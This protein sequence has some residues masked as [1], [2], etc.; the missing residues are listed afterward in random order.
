MRTILVDNYDS[1]SYNVFQLMA[2]TFGVEPTVLANDAPEWADIDLA[3]YAAVVIS[4]GPGSPAEPGDRGVALDHLRAGT[5]PVLGV[6]LGHQALGWLAGGSVVPAPEPRHGYLETIR[7]S[8]TELF[9]GVPQDF[10]AVRY[11]SLCLAE[12]LP[13]DLEATAW[14]PD[15]VVMGVRH[16]RLPWWGVQFHPE[17]VASEHGAAIFANFAELVRAE[18][19]GGPTPLRPQQRT[20]RRRTLDFTV[21]T[22]VL[23]EELFA[24]SRFAFW[25]DSSRVER[26][27]SRFSFL[28][29]AGGGLGEVLSARV[30]TGVVH[31]VTEDGRVRATPGSIFDTLEERLR[32]HRLPWD[33]ALPFDLACGYVGYFGYEMRDECGSPT[34]HVSPQPDA[35]WMTASRM[36]AVDH[37]T[38]TTWVFALADGGD[39]SVR[40]AQAWVDETA[41]RIEALR[42]ARPR[43]VAH[44]ER[45]IDV[46]P[47]LHR[48]RAR[49]LA[50][51]AECTAS[52][53]AGES[54]EICLTNGLDLPFTGSPL[55]AYRWLRRRSPAPYAAYLRFDE[56]HVLSSSPERFLTVDAQGTVES[57][58][59]KGTARRDPDPEVDRALRDELAGSDKTRAENLMI[60]DLLR[61][62]LGRICEIGSIRVPGFMK[63]E[64]YA[65]VHQLVSTIR[66]R[67]RPEVGPVAAVRAAFPGGSMTGAPKLRTMQIIDALEQRPRG[68]YSGALGFFGFQG[69]ADLNIVIR[70]ATIESGRASIGAGG[71]IVLDSDP[72]DEY[73]EMTLKAAAVVQAVAGAGGGAR[74]VAPCARPERRSA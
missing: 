34:D 59:I 4:P 55:E 33:S 1:Y 17:S 5:I 2:A 56:L 24:D 27:L 45:E 25:L 58:P 18:H 44:E 47:L 65:T 41:G 51:I 52:L 13:E 31:V 10:T 40:R 43:P 15:G 50:D 37:E 19:R 32:T 42:G 72:V 14:S 30:G 36:V 68:I 6:C 70:T 66:G 16:R 3:D 57:K 53:H 62:D 74:G 73:D 38:D 23:F 11:H 39:G 12:P 54:Y 21:S 69:A 67:L 20:L 61:N 35:Q 64:S 28:G 49:Y 29:D 71:A 7:H 26:G 48:S 46:E 60:V 22:E 9:R 63:V 8:G